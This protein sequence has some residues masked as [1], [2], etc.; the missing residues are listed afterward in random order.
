MSTQL[1]LGDWLIVSADEPARADWGVAIAGTAV[2]DIGHHRDLIERHPTASVM[3]RPGCVVMPG[4]VNAHIHLYGVLAHGI[5]PHSPPSGF[6]D[7]LSDYWWPQVE[8]RLDPSM[9]ATAARQVS[10]EAALGGTTTIFDICEAPNAVDDA[11]WAIAEQVRDVGLRARL[12]FEATQRA[13]ADIAE[14]ALQANRAFIDSCDA[15]DIVGGVMSWHTTFT[16]DADYIATAHG[17]ARDAHAWTHAHC[18]E[19]RHEG[20][21]MRS[22]HD[23]STLEFYDRIGVLDDQLHLSQCVQ[24]EPID[25][26]L[27]AARGVAISHM[28]MSN[29]EVGGGIAPVPEL[30]A[31]GVRIG[32]GSDGYVNDMF[33]VMRMA[34]H[35]HKARLLDPSVAPARQVVAHATSIGAASLGLDHV[36]SLHPE[37]AA[38]LQVV[39]MATPTPVTA[40]NIFDQIVLWRS[41]RDVTDTMVAGRWVVCDGQPV[42][43]DHE[44]ASAATH[45]EAQRLWAIS[46]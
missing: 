29:C 13:G 30:H 28:P 35:I 25:L 42:N 17:L 34:F 1:V 9:L 5:T 40:E 19:G 2:C 20:A 21:T 39:S 11:L 44:A 15:D 3:R 33:E 22:R 23:C 4:F 38:D 8:N 7:F 46:R 10:I 45:K 14:R 6:D 24:L 27:I 43:V 26:E 16:C 41:A 12:S 18:N 37:W 32:L 31:A 36:G